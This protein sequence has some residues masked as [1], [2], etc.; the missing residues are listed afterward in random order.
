MVS[1]WRLKHKVA[2]LIRAAL[3]PGEAQPGVCKCGSA[4]HDV[5]RIRIVRRGGKAGV[6][7]T[8]ACGSPWLCPTCAP[9]RAAQRVQRLEA[10]FD[11][12]E[13]RGWSLVFCTLTASHGPRDAL[14]DLK[15]LVA[16]SSRKA[17][18]GRAWVDL[19]VEH[20]VEG[21]INGPE[22]TWSR[23]HGWHYHQHLAVLVSTSDPVA[24]EAAG[25]AL[26][27]RYLAAVR[28]S[29]GKAL[30]AGQDVQVVWRREDVQAYLAKGSAAWEVAAA[31]VG[32]DARG[33]SLTPWDLAAAG[34]EGDQL[35]AA[36]FLEYAKS[37]PGTRSCV[38]TAAIAAK[39]GIATADD[40]DG[41]LQEEVA[42]EEIG[43]IERETWHLLLRR[44]RVPDVLAAVDRGMPWCE[45]EGFIEEWA[46]LLPPW[47]GWGSIPPP[48]MPA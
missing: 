30:P 38:V 31:G 47:W 23:R 22:V 13:K 39:L 17:R 48:P 14:E 3:R 2:G 18:Q 11:A 8:L 45:V 1:R 10:V 24:A 43:A 34:S 32:K 44:G 25:H 36:R 16:G 46:G 19:A 12:A 29:G 4:S 35:A 5:A 20:G 37:M 41:E 6:R 40:A 28:K 9:R 21:V 26:L 7:G 15:A 42:D 27:A 33:Q